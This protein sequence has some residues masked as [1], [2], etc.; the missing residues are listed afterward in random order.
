MSD[1]PRTPRLLL[2]G[3]DGTGRLFAP[4]CAHL[5]PTIEPR[6]IAYPGDHALDYR[7]L[8]ELV[9]PQLPTS[10][11]WFVLGESFSGP[12]ALRLADERPPGLAGIILVAS[13]ASSPLAW[14]PR[15]S[16]ALVRPA[17]FHGLGLAPR[18]ALGLARCPPEITAL[19][20]ESLAAVAP[21]VM[22]ARA[23]AILEL[24]A[25]PASEALRE[26]PAL[27]L[28][29]RHDRLIARRHTAR[30]QALLPRAQLHWLAAP[31][32]LLQACPEQAAAHIAAWI[33]AQP[34]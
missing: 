32:L 13:F 23:R 29:A 20:R 14:L 30:L 21:A 1:A 19:L 12:L 6:T 31:H 24:A 18:H 16:H 8:A 7:E 17:L 4:L 9:R 28:A 34:A 10:G 22:A 25:P 33:E 15:W 27:L 3:M 11:R 2:P 5:P 26:L